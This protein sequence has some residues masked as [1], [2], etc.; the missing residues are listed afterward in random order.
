MR[1]PSDVQIDA[2]IAQFTA[3]KDAVGVACWA[4]RHRGLC[5]NCDGP[6]GVSAEDIVTGRRHLTCRGCHWAADISEGQ[7]RGAADVQLRGIVGAI[8]EV[9]RVREAARNVKKRTPRRPRAPRRPM[10]TPAPPHTDMTD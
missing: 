4:L 9:R 5:P 6:V 7:F 8:Y 3:A 10:P 2:R 1:T